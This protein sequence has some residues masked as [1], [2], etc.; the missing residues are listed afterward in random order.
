MSTFYY[1][2]NTRKLLYEMREPEHYLG[3]NMSYVYDN[4]GNVIEKTEIPIF[5]RFASDP[6]H[7]VFR[8]YDT[9]GIRL[10]SKR[11]GLGHVES[12]TYDHFGN[13]VKFTDINGLVTHYTYDAFDRKTSESRPD[14]TIIRMEIGFSQSGY[15]VWS[16]R[17][18][19]TGKQDTFTMYDSL[20]R[21]IKVVSTGYG[22]EKIHEDIVYDSLGR[23]QK[24][25]LPY[26]FKDRNPA[27][28][29]S[30]YD[31]LGREISQKHPF[32]NTTATTRTVYKGLVREITDANGNLKRIE[33][34]ARGKIVRITDAMGGTVAYKYDTVGNLIKTTDPA[35]HVTTMTYDKLGNKISM[36]DPDMGLW[37]YLHDAHG[38]MVWQRDAVGNE[39]FFTYDKLGRIIQR[40]A[41][42][43]NSKWI[44]DTSTN[45]KGKLARAVSPSGHVME[46]TYDSK[47][48]EAAVR[49]KIGKEVFSVHSEYNPLGQLSRQILPG[50]K[51]VNYCYDNQGFTTKVTQSSCGQGF[52]GN[53]Y[54]RALEYDAFG[55]IA[56]EEYAN[57]L[58]TE[59]QYDD[60]NHIKSIKTRDPSMHVKRPLGIQLR[61]SREHVGTKR[62]K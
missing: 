27:W 38:Q 57:S 4:N 34:D 35:G 6:P 25:S 1:N 22:G 41:P 40:K 52:S 50:N 62:S 8:N 2:R 15:G 36:N 54:W 23:V 61:C 12:Y 10:M 3:L 37:N 13:M 51:I 43:G 29:I 31:E 48:R 53:G 9:Q 18:V 60:S 16:K 42:E 47:G 17:I 55:H 58:L 19:Q 24:Q 11:N 14:G 28:V 49:Q 5:P 44:Y 30:E 39:V 21:P 56:K 7:K 33:K 26:F 46:Y 59:Y 32:E 45:G 20:D